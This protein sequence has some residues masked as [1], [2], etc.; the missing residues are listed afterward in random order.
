MLRSSRITRMQLTSLHGLDI[1]QKLTWMMNPSSPEGPD[2]STTVIQLS[3]EQRI[4]Q[5]LLQVDEDKETEWIQREPDYLAY[6]QHLSNSS[7]LIQR[8]NNIKSHI[9]SSCEFGS[10]SHSDKSGDSAGPPKKASLSDTRSQHQKPDLPW[11]RDSKPRDIKFVFKHY[12][13]CKKYIKQYRYEHT[14]NCG[15]WS[16]DSDMFVNMNLPPKVT[17]ENGEP[18]LPNTPSSSQRRLSCSN[19]SSA[20]QQ[21][22]AI[23]RINSDSNILELATRYRL[24]SSVLK[25]IH[26]KY[27]SQVENSHGA[28]DSCSQQHNGTTQHDLT[29]KAGQL[30]MPTSKIQSKHSSSVGSNKSTEINRSVGPRGYIH[31]STGQVLMGMAV[32]HFPTRASSPPRWVASTQ[33]LMHTSECLN[34]LK[35]TSLK[36][37]SC[38]AAMKLC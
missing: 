7:R 8:T 22:Q 4:Q 24:A 30:L 9:I 15:A 2:S 14:Y 1:L 34:V 35:M 31:A 21:R 38:T 11:L 20:T 18:K 26:Q 28:E 17:Q 33:M 10:W 36:V 23:H 25:E 29:I 6:V 27:S 5:N 12:M 13:D 16:A 19:P 37:S 32:K 3:P